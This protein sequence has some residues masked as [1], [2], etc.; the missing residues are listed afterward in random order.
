M[1]QITGENVG[2]RVNEVERQQLN[3]FAT[4]WQE[5]EKTT[6]TNGKQL[7]FSL[8]TYCKQLE[9]NLNSTENTSENNLNST[10]NT[11]ENNLNSTENT[12]EVKQ[13]LIHAVGYETTP[14]DDELFSDLLE[15]ITTPLEPAPT[16]EIEKIVEKTLQPGEIILPL[17]EKQLEV[18]ELIARYRAHFK[19]DVPRKT[20]AELVKAIVF[21]KEILTNEFGTFPTYLQN[22]KLK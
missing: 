12:S 16:V 2:F 14:T 7:V 15:I 5:K 4:F 9:N 6:F 18:L 21:Q 13:Q 22:K 10:E 17:T 1:Y 3:E 20:P 8:L 11:S 19:D